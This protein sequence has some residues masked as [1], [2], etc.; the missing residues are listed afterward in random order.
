M[1]RL[2]DYVFRQLADWG[3]RQVFLL[4]GGGA[5]HLNDAIGLEP[6]LRYLCMH[7]EQA[8]AMAAE[9]YARIC[10]EPAILNVTTGPGAINALNG[11]FGA[12]TDSI[13]MIVISGQVKR[14]TCMAAYGA[15]VAG[16]RQLGDQEVDIV[17]MV[18]GITKYAEIILDPSTIRYHLERAFYLATHGRPGP[19]W[20]D[21]PVDVQSA[22]IDES[23][24]P[25]YDEAQDRM[26]FDPAQIRTQCEDLLA[27]LERAERPVIMV[28]SGIRVAHAYDQFRSVIDRL[29]IP[30]TTAWT[31]IDLLP[32]D[33]PLYCG[34]PG[35][36]GNRAG[37]FA[38]QNSDLL[39]VLG[40]RLHFRQIS[41]NW[42]SFARHAFKIQVDID[43]AELRKPTVR[44]D[45]GIHADLHQFFAILAELLD[46]SKSWKSGRHAVWLQWCK[47]RV[48]RYPAVLPQY[49]QSRQPINPYHFCDVFFDVLGEGGIVACGDGAASVM[50]FQAARMKENQRLYS[51]AGSASMGYDLPAAIGAAL[52]NNGRQVICF[53]GDGSLQLNIQDLQTIVHHRLPVKIFVFNNGGYL[54][55][56][57]TQKSFFNGNFI[58]EG[59]ASGISFPDIVR[60]AEAYGIPAFRLED[61]DCAGALRDFLSQPGPGLCEVMLDP[62]QGIEPR[63]TSRILPDGKMVSS[64]IEDMYP[65]LDPE[66]LRSNMLVGEA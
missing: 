56:R 57:T 19:V 63:L 6:R 47:D 52:A 54:S 36:V 3:V 39:L 49:S 58:G 35:T 15:E 23:T 48:A 17:R 16:L 66:E 40:C 9:S 38:V 37:N 13:P 43:E 20:L 41:Y 55:I 59:P 44:P 51:N 21:I 29:G 27:R 8:C 1:I 5:M 22:R 24:L 2:A 25:G 42:N 14:E 45:I 65:F 10:G 11:V 34:R 28:G 64:A 7:H 4:T 30:V 53:A 32:S 46:R 31:A 62:A 18:K 26:S 61:G 50:P 60:V 12:W 33:H